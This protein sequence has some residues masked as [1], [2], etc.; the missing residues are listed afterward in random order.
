MP[1]GLAE[2]PLAVGQLSPPSTSRFE[3]RPLPAERSRDFSGGSE[4]IRAHDTT[5]RDDCGAHPHLPLASPCSV[6]SA[7]GGE[8]CE[9]PCGLLRHRGRVPRREQSG[10]PSLP[11][12]GAL[13]SPRVESNTHELPTSLPRRASCRRSSSW[14]RYLRLSDY[15]MTKIDSRAYG[16]M[17]GNRESSHSS[18]RN[19]PTASQRWADCLRRRFRGMRR[20][21][22]SSRS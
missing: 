3:G 4:R 1:E 11:R 16:R 22:T 18:T 13:S 10:H 21:E 6:A 12:V 17:R 5:V 7:R 15:R 2:F 8:C 9:L 19:T 20:V 14:A